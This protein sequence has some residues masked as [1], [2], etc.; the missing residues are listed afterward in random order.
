MARKRGNVRQ[1]RSKPPLSQVGEEE[2]EEEVADG[3]EK[4]EEEEDHHHHLVGYSSGSQLLRGNQLIFL[5][6]FFYHFFFSLS[7]F[8]SCNINIYVKKKKKNPKTLLTHL[9]FNQNE[10]RKKP[11]QQFR[12]WIFYWSIHLKWRPCQPGRRGP[13]CSFRMDW[14]GHLHP[15]LRVGKFDRH[16]LVMQVD[17]LGSFFL[18]C[19]TSVGPP[20]FHN[21]HTGVLI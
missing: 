2:K 14:L 3:E 10:N 13:G 12:V 8:L 15:F 4:E 18:L 20:L 6:I 7:L 9:T 16:V 11:A 5:L 19:N 21:Y 1:F 17:W